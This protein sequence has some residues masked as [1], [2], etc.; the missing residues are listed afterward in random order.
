MCSRQLSLIIFYVNS[1]KAHFYF[2]TDNAGSCCLKSQKKE[3]SNV[4]NA[5]DCCQK[6]ILLLQ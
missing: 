5:T 3:M 2:H 6:T 1:I 4:F